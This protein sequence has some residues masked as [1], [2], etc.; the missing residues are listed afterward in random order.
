M[1]SPEAAKPLLPAFLLHHSGSFRPA[2]RGTRSPLG[3]SFERAKETKTRLG[4]S[5]LSTPPG[6]PGCPCVK[7]RFGPSPLLWPLLMPPHQATMGSRPYNQAISTAGPTLEK[8]RS[9]RR[10]PGHR[11]LGTVAHQGEALEVKVLFTREIGISGRM[12]TPSMWPHQTKG[13]KEKSAGTPRTAGWIP[14]GGG[15][16]RLWRFFSRFLIGEKSGP[17]ER[18]WKGGENRY[19]PT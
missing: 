7:A 11:Q 4:L 12:S 9:R 13:Q 17:A 6:V 10:E 8:R 1:F 15:R 18:L 16:P 3:V 2:R 19:A 14:Q 5:P